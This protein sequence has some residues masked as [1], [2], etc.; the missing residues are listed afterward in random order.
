MVRFA[1]A[2]LVASM[3]AGTAFADS[4][5]K[6]GPGDTRAKASFQKFADVWMDKMLKM[7]SEQKTASTYRD[8]GDDVRVELKPTGSP[9]IPYVGLL[10]YTEQ[11]HTCAGAGHTNCTVSSSIPVTEIFRFQNGRWVY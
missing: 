5:A 1:L 10:R 2:T 7:A 3:L 11:N 8:Y 4:P 9:D 6:L